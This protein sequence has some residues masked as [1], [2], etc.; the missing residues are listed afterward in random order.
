MNDSQI[1]AGYLA[2]Q[3]VMIAGAIAEP[4]DKESLRIAR[5]LII[6][7]LEEGDVDPVTDGVL[8]KIIK[9]MDGEF[10]E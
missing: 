9:I 4:F 10:V 3:I 8:R 7:R 1:F 5:E 6:N 2:T